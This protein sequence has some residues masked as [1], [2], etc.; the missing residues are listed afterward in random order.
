MTFGAT[1]RTLSD[2]D[3][4]GPWQDP[5]AATDAAIA[6]A[7]GLEQ[8]EPKR[9]AMGTL[10]PADI[11][12][13][14]DGAVIVSPPAGQRAVDA[15]YASP[16]VRAGEQAR[17]TDDVYTIGAIL[18][19]MLHGVA[20]TPRRQPSRVVP[21][22]LA[23]IVARAMAEAPDDRYATLTAL[24]VD[25]QA[26]RPPR[27]APAAPVP[28]AAPRNDLWKLLSAI[29]AAALAI[30]LIVLFTRPG[31][32]KVPDVV[33][34]PHLTARQELRD[35]G[36]RVT[37][38]AGTSDIVPTGAAI[39]TDPPKGTEVPQGSAVLLVINGNVAAAAQV[40]NVVGQQQAQAEQAL[41]SA[42]LRSSVANVPDAAPAGTVIRQTPESGAEATP[43]SIIQL[44]VSS[45]VAVTT[46]TQTDTQTDTQ[47]TTA[48]V[49][50]TDTTT[51]TETTTAPTA[52][53][54][55]PP[56]G[57]AV[58]SV[59]GK[60]RDTATAELEAA[61]FTVTVTE[62]SSTTAAGTV[63][64]QN[65]AAGTTSAAGTAIALEVA[66]P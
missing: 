40:P 33:G 52:T 8:V 2:I 44:T 7:A 56:G 62:V 65:P 47:T 26:A 3:A 59:V 43:G 13:R 35:K 39:R 15:R 11:A 63:L 14:P 20:D 5:W 57:I 37:L 53:S 23:A 31:D 50:V 28:A 51:A 58:P 61:G 64:S 36:F 48:I 41:A 1:P 24:R 55:A 42:G 4:A 34:K 16:Q 49:T 25:L 38:A 10:T 9:G 45:G 54:P 30:A 19:E 6:I 29:L 27:P 60:T 18:D 46:E 32:V 17:A 21:P 12:L 22:E 66:A